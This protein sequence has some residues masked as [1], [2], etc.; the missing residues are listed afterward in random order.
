MINVSFFFSPED[1]ETLES[2]TSSSRWYEDNDHKK[3]L[4]LR[5]SDNLIQGE[6]F[7]LFFLE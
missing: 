5:Q 6:N 7:F 2:F 1:K 4:S 3:N